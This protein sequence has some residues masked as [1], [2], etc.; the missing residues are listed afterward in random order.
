MSKDL[1]KFLYDAGLYEEAKNKNLVIA[2]HPSG[3]L[4]KAW[5]ELTGSLETKPK[6]AKP[7]FNPPKKVETPEKIEVT[8]NT[9]TYSSTRSELLDLLRVEGKRAMSKRFMVLC[10]IPH[11]LK[12]RGGG[13]YTVK[14]CSIEAQK[15][16]AEVIQTDN[17]NID[18]LIASVKWYYAN[19]RL[20]RK[21][22]TNYILSDECV[23]YYEEYETNGTTGLGPTGS[24]SRYST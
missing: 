10:E 16:L 6:M 4:K 7:E 9:K 8:E 13:E 17:I 3:K 2:E 18:T 15:V 22:F 12:F 21:S 24:R 1:I 23:T 14:T 19:P 5:D 11:K 20:S